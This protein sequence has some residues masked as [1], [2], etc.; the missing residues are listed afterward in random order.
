LFF[1]YY[2][3]KHYCLK[4]LT[5]TKDKK[6]V[7]PPGEHVFPFYYNLPSTFPSSFNGDHGSIQYYIEADIVL[8]QGMETQCKKSFTVQSNIDI[9]T[10]PQANERLEKTRS[11]YICCFCC[12]SGPITCRCWIPKRGYRIGEQILFCAEIENLSNR[13]IEKSH[14]QL[15]QTIIYHAKKNKQKK[16][17]KVIHEA[18]RTGFDHEDYWADYK[19]DLP[20]M[21]PSPFQGSKL[22]EVTYHIKMELDVGPLEKNVI[23]ELPIMVGGPSQSNAQIGLSSIAVQPIQEEYAE[24]PTPSAPHFV[25][26]SYEN[27]APHPDRGEYSYH[28]VPTGD[29]PTYDEL[30]IRKDKGCGDVK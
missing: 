17:T 14:L 13:S 3:T 5:Q 28:P 20:F 11:K 9:S 1:N 19:I 27:P 21:P 18:S 16:V 10:L 4:D 12:R 26:Y 7:L 2:Y 6:S 15:I 29:P 8:A 22:F 25:A 23:I 30:Y 24:R